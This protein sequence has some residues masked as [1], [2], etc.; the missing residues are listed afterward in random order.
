MNPWGD[1]LD[2]Q[3]RLS[4]QPCGHGHLL[5]IPLAA[6]GQVA[7]VPPQPP[8]FL[9]HDPL[10][11]GLGG[12]APQLARVMLEVNPSTGLLTSLGQRL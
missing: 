6:A 9:A 7:L 10:G 4:P 1:L 3:R 8:Q 5:G 11:L 2:R 12:I